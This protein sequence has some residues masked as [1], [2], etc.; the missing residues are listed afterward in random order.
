[1]NSL[2][3]LYCTS[4]LPARRCKLILV[5][6]KVSPWPFSVNSLPESLHSWFPSPI[7]CF[8]FFFSVKSHV[9][10]TLKCSASV[11]LSQ[12]N[13]CEL[14]LPGCPY[15]KFIPVDFWLLSPWVIP[16]NFVYSGSCLETQG[17]FYYSFDC[18]CHAVRCSEGCT[19]SIFQIWRPGLREVLHHCV[20]LLMDGTL[21]SIP[22]SVSRPAFFMLHLLTQVFLG[23]FPGVVPCL[24]SG[25]ASAHHTFDE[26][27]LGW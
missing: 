8:F 27:D 7:V 1:M 11:P 25:F 4:Y 6:Q 20:A 19:I 13:A 12:H 14:R 18:Q 21:M 22:G 17:C 3:L 9:K 23:L 26:K 15:L 5:P 10:G 2:P 24:T 16:H